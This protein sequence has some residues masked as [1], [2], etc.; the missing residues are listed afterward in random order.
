L[1]G[2]DINK[3]LKQL[4]IRDNKLNFSVSMRSN[5]AILGT[6]T[7]VAFFCLLQQQMLKLLFGIALLNVIQMMNVFLFLNQ[8]K[9]LLEMRE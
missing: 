5:D 9:V 7:D 2:E 1:I 6:P 4:N 8:L 3:T